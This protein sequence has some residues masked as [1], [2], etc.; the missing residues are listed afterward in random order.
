[1]IPR[2]NFKKNHKNERKK[3]QFNVTQF[4]N[5]PSKSLFF[6]FESNLSSGI[7]LLAPSITKER[8]V[9]NNVK[10]EEDI[11]DQFDS[12]QHLI[13]TSFS[14]YWQLYSLLQ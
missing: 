9:R 13:K 4:P 2:E 10:K 14:Q 11:P 1:M 7:M 8:F 12:M 3:N 5:I 6:R